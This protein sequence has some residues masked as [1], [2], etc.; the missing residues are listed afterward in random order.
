[1][2]DLAYIAANTGAEWSS[3]GDIFTTES[4]NSDSTGKITLS[5]TP[6]PVVT[7][8]S[9]VLYYRKASEA[10]GDYTKRTLTNTEISTKEVVLGDDY[11]SQEICVLY[12]YSNDFAEKIT[13]SS[14]FIPDTLHAV[15][16]VAL[17]AG[18]SC[19]V[20]SS[21]KVGEVTIDVPRFQLS[22]SM[23]L[24]MCT[25]CCQTNSQNWRVANAA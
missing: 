4:L 25:T 20:E 10:G 8:G 9:A 24:T 12:R 18:D 1:M 11:K 5:K 7:G 17:Y 6:V 22:G 3:K 23:D 13:I 19:N 16:T 14:Q 21:T 15:L 2:F